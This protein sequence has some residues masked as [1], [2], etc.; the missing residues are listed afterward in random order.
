M[1]R[2][3]GALSKE[4]DVE[5]GVTATT[6]DSRSTTVGTQ[7]AAI[8]NLDRRRHPRRRPG[9]MSRSPMAAAS[10]P[11]SSTRLARGSP[12]ATSSPR[13]P[14]GNTTVMVEVTGA[15]M[16]AALENGFSQLPN[17]AGRFPQVSGLKVEVD[18]K[19]PAGARVISIEVDGKPLDP[20][21]RYK[22]ASNNF[23]LAGGD[24][25]AALGRGRV[26]IGP[27]TA[28]SWRTR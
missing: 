24:D 13:L 4:L 14:F 25:Y 19:L 7:E 15:D 26:L 8:G 9:P 5:V 3:E 22:V 18:P 1:Q 6:L 17:R 16:R 10:G 2:Y 27:P 12:G 28:S 20:T 11:E 21:A 23:L